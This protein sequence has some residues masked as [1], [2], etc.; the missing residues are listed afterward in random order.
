MRKGIGFILLAATLLA[1]VLFAACTKSTDL[2]PVEERISALESALAAIEPVAGAPT[3]RF[4]DIT[5]V[6]NVGTTETTRED[7]PEVDP[8]IDNDGIVYKA[9]GFADNPDKWEVE[10]YRWAPAQMTANQGDTLNLQFFIVQGKEHEAWIEGPDGETVMEEITME[11]GRLYN[12]TVVLSK[13]GVYRLICNTHEPWMTAVIG[14]LP[15]A[16][17]SGGT[18]ETDGAEGTPG[19]E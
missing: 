6:E 15:T 12:E 11:R 16:G 7:P 13:P 19:A 18:G 8:S 10:A 9:P 17:S 4:I 1:S 5:A 14:V 2:G 3:E